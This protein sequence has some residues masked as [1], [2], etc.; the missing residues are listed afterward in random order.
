MRDYLFRAKA[1]ENK[2]GY[3]I[4]ELV[5]GS[6]RRTTMDDF[7]I[8]DFGTDIRIKVDA[9]TVGQY[10]GIK[11]RNGCMVYEGDIVQDP[12]L[13]TLAEIVWN[14]ENARFYVRF[15]EKM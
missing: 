5:H 15:L 6:L 12:E 14:K 9:E 1:A 13:G 8:Y 4:G 3:K 2:G 7:Y 11:D 10:T